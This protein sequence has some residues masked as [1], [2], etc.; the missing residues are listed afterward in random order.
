MVGDVGTM[1]KGFLPR[2]TNLVGGFNPFEKYE[3][4]E[5]NWKSSPNKSENEQYLKPLHQLETPKNHLPVLPLK[6]YGTIPGS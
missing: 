2:K 5:S 6:K 4:Y 1:K 3:I